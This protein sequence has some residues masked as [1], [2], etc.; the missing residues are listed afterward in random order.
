[1]AYIPAKMDNS[2]VIHNSESVNY[3]VSIFVVAKN[4]YPWHTKYA[5]V[6]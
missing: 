5:V 2:H 4:L 3:C 6:I 1:M